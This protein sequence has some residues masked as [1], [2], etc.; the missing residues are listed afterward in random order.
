MWCHEK[1]GDTVLA[2]LH[3]DDSAGLDTLPDDGNDGLFEPWSGGST[4]HVAGALA[5][6]VGFAME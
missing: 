5:G 6:R 4:G 2:A 3:P 1:W